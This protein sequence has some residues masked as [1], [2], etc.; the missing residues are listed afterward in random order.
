MNY[1]PANTSN[2]PNNQSGGL[3]MNIGIG[4]ILGLLTALLAV[5]LVT[6]NG[7]PFKKQDANTFD[8]SGQVTDPNEPLYGT[9]STPIIT[10]QP[11]ET[12]DTN[13]TRILPIETTVAINTQ[14]SNDVITTIIANANTERSTVIKVI[15]PETNAAPKA[16]SNITPKAIKPTATPTASNS[17]SNSIKKGRYTIQAGAF[18]DIKDANA[19]KKKL[20]AQG[21]PVSIVE[22]KTTNGSLYR[23]RVGNYSSDKEAQA[24]RSRIGG[25]VL[26]LNN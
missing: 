25:V 24:A 14:P 10:T 20:S 22:K 23:V 7:G 16:E 21:Q 26:E 2:N 4:I 1:S 15:K 6:K 3:I 18:E 13:S 19:L 5:F 12:N 17:A 9:N 8:A 11:S